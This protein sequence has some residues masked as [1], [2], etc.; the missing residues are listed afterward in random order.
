MLR[1]DWPRESI[2]VLDLR[3]N[4]S[5]TRR[6]AA[7]S[8]FRRRDILS[9]GVNRLLTRIASRSLLVCFAALAA[10]ALCAPLAALLSAQTPVSQTTTSQS[11]PAQ[12]SAPTQPAAPAASTFEIHGH[13][14]GEPVK[15]FLRLE[16]EARGEV[17][18]CH[19]NPNRPACGRLLDA[20]E[21]NKRAEISTSAPVDTDHP[22]GDRETTDWVLDSG[23]LVKISMLV[24]EAPDALKTLGRP[25]SEKS[26][27]SQNAA[28][29]KWENR[30]T[31]WQSA[32][33]YVALYLDNN[34]R[35]TD[36]RLS[37]VVETPAEHARDNP[38]ADPPKPTP[39][40]P[41]APPS[42]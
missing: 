10:A 24:N 20:V 25:T 39:A 42:N 4:R 35:L 38:D 16:L 5:A 18:V 36:H 30:L 26:I 19:E 6:A 33:L 31:V 37:L 17:E 28:G 9:A 23:K 7:A 1:N 13:V 34:P 27:P 8:L 15:R 21:D 11:A 40:T 14:I 41:P 2:D 3:V 22:E 29:A 32:D 12:Q